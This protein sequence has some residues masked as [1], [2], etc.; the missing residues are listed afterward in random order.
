MGLFDFFNTDEHKKNAVAI[1][2]DLQAGVLERCPICGTVFD[3]EHDE[4]LP[5]ADA[6]AHE[7][8]DRND[9]TV[10]IF[11]GN[12]EDLLARLRS[13]RKPLPYACTCENEG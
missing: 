4:R 13:A 11:N 5:T 2:I 7:A 3:R 12:R 1:E 6:A 10:A 8:F 9:P